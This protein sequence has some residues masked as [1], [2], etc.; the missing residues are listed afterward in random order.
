MYSL[1]KDFHEEIF[2]GKT[3]EV[4]S[5]G[6]FQIDICFSDKCWIHIES[7]FKLYEKGDLTEEVSNFPLEQTSLL[8]LLGCVITDISRFENEDLSIS[9]GDKVLVILGDVGPY[10]AYRIC[11]GTHEFL[12]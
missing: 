4:I 11:D 12:V 9:F 1:S 3:V 6:K 10:E 7:G 2:K 8:N 5:F